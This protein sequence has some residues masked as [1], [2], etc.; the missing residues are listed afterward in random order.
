MFM[1]KSVSRCSAS[2]IRRVVDRI[3]CATAAGQPPTYADLF[4]AQTFLINRY[5]QR[6]QRESAAQ[7]AQ[8]LRLQKVMEAAI[9][10][11]LQ[12]SPDTL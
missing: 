4:L 11:F 8:A 2:A 7:T 10:N 3:Y 9:A 6:D 12:A 1:Q 5:I